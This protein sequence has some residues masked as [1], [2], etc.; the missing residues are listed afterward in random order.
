MSDLEL[1]TD[2]RVLRNGFIIGRVEWIEDGDYSDYCFV[3]EKDMNFN[4]EEIE[5]IKKGLEKI[6]K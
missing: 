1:T 2:Y 3:P 6:K 4:L 5:L